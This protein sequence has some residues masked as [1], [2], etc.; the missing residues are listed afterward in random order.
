MF[1]FTIVMPFING[2]KYIVFLQVSQLCLILDALLEPDSSRAEVLESHFLEAVYCS[3]GASL[4]G[5]DRI[6]F[7]E[8]VKRLSCLTVVYEEK[9]LAGPGEIPGEILNL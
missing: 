7:D 3:L 5:N 9:L 4:L 2:V 8:H 1:T 6:T